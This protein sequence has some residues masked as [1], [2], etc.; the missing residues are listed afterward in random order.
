MAAH[1]Q[2]G[3]WDAVDSTSWRCNSKTSAVLL[4]GFLV[5]L[6]AAVLTIHTFEADSAAFQLSVERS[7]AT[8]TT[9]AQHRASRKPVGLV[10]IAS[11]CLNL[12]EKRVWC[13]LSFFEIAWSTVFQSQEWLVDDIGTGSFEC[14]ANSVIGS[15][16]LD[17]IVRSAV[18][19]L[20]E[21]LFK[22]LN[23]LLCC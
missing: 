16:R 1:N 12:Y 13:C 22:L 3:I 9:F 5:L 8:F 4:V 6:R 10:V 17:E 19:V 11:L 7:N 15:V 18:V 2:G 23:T 14:K 20:F 21:C